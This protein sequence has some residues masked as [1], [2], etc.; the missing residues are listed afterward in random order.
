MT[1]LTFLNGIFISQTVCLCERNHI[2]SFSHRKG[3]QRVPICVCVTGQKMEK[4]SQGAFH[5]RYFPASV[6]HKLKLVDLYSD[7]SV[8]INQCFLCIISCNVKKYEEDFEA[9]IKHHLL[10][11]QNCKRN[12]FFNASK[13]SQT[14][15]TISYKILCQSSTFSGVWK[16]FLRLLRFEN[17]SKYFY[18]LKFGVDLLIQM[19][20]V[21]INI[22][23]ETIFQN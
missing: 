7:F 10:S 15:N 19:S 23:F 13:R 17:S 2:L 11:L 14:I 3:F 1:N 18:Q 8:C 21:H 4:Y 6:W 20:G 22:K 5:G 12:Q 16:T 9:R